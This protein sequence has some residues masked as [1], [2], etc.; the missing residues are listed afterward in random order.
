[1][2]TENNISTKTSGQLFAGSG[3]APGN[4]N[5]YFLGIGGIGM[6]ALA[7]YFN[8]LGYKV[9]GYDKTETPLTL[10][11]KCE[12]ISVHYTDDITLAD[13]QAGLVVYTPAVPK[14]HAEFNFF[15]KNN[16]N[17]K[18]RSEV[19]GLITKDGMN[20]CVAGTHGKTTTSAMIAHL[21]TNSGYGCNAFLG[22]I[23]T[24]YD[25]N[26]L[27]SKDAAACVVEADEY[28][29]S[30]LQ[31]SPDVAVITA[32]DA[33]HL[34]IYGTEKNMQ[35]AFIQFAEKIKPGGLL[36]VKKGLQRNKEFKA[37]KK[38]SY[39]LSDSTAD[40]YVENIQVQ[41]GKY[42]FD[43]QVEDKKLA[44]LEFNM[45]GQHNIENML[46]AI[47]VGI[48]LQINEDAIRKAVSSFKGVKR[49]F[50]TLLKT[51]NVVLIDDYAHHPEELRALI[52][53]AKE[54]YPGWHSTIVF[55][56]HLYSRTQAHA[57]GFAEVLSTAD[58]SFLL[59]IYPAR[60]EPIAGVSS[61][62]I[63]REMTNKN[64]LVTKE[65]LLELIKNKTSEIKEKQLFIMAGA[66][67]IDI[68]L[69]PVKQLLEVNS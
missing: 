43:V 51:N 3:D 2:S 35:D 24:N 47:A 66:G 14:D 31:L 68:L 13:S 7:R 65:E 15:K 4:R 49:R 21:L 26:F 45:G 30:F 58:E 44:G 37:G 11:L 40:I 53:G 61:E 62:L 57:S 17:L 12:G 60:E 69:L 32:M 25:S 6:S 39:H 56:P 18:K 9:S 16:Y 38:L 54:L 23:A 59:P 10:Q 19:L 42:L 36:L 34:D 22:G 29:R 63:S 20:I 46:A 52:N 64:R 33:D 41:E 28:D 8:E 27:S 48:H 1:M 55:Q 67:D 50:E 5:V